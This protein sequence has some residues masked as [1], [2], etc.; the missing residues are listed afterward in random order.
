MQYA[1]VC[2]CVFRSRLAINQP[3]QQQRDPAA[4]SN[5]KGV[6]NRKDLVANLW[7]GES[8]AARGRWG[9]VW[10]WFAAP[11][12]NADVGAEARQADDITGVV[13][14]FVARA[15]VHADVDKTEGERP[16]V[17][18]NRTSDSFGFLTFPFGFVSMSLHI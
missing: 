8:P 10:G 12:T 14:W 13:M 6:F 1:L 4:T 15:L 7:D 11:P 3:T 17:Q 2:A 5:R 9:W 18:E 16:A